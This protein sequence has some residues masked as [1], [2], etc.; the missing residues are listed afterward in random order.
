MEGPGI[1]FFGGARQLIAAQ[2]RDLSYYS[3]SSERWVQVAM[4]TAIIADSAADRTGPTAPGQRC[5]GRRYR[6][7]PGTYPWVS[8]KLSCFSLLGKPQINFCF[9]CCLFVS[10]SFFRGG[11]TVM[12]LLWGLVRGVSEVSGGRGVLERAGL[13]IR[14]HLARTSQESHNQNPGR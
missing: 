4:A 7:T 14:W 13:T 1:R 10:S 8:H 2:A 3:E 6:W 5:E 12:C 9:F 11:G